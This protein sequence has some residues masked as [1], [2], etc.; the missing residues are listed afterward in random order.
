MIALEFSYNGPLQTGVWMMLKKSEERYDGTNYD[1]NF[2]RLHSGFHPTGNLFIGMGLRLGDAIDYDNGRLGSR[3]GGGPRIDWKI[4]DNL[5]FYTDLTHEQLDV[6]GEDYYT[7]NM[8]DNRLVYH[9]NQKTFIRATVQYTHTDLNPDVDESLFTQLLFSYKVNP[10]TVLFVGY[11]D[12][13][14]GDNEWDMFR[15]DRT[16]FMK[17]AYAWQ[18]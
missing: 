3:L 8:L 14:Y 11:S 15:Y 17:A 10:Q 6:N 18:P 5:Q 9:F 13:I 7:V 1:M 12:N 4:T 16:V 2:F